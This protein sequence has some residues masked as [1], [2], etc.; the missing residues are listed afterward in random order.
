M[1]DQGGLKPVDYYTN[2]IYNIFL[3]PPNKAAAL[4]HLDL[5]GPPPGRFARVIVIRG[6]QIVPDVMEYKVTMT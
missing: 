3:L 6:A 2:T 4:A 1:P 5:G